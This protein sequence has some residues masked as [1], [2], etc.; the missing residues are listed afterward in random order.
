MHLALNCFPDAFF[1][2]HSYVPPKYFVTL[3]KCSNWPVIS[4]KS[5]SLKYQFVYPIEW[6]LITCELPSIACT[7]F[8]IIL[9][10]SII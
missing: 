5:F 10:G 1:P 2:W 7:E 6:H 8:G 3:F 9:S 4:G